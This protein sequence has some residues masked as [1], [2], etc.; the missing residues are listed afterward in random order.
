MAEDSFGLNHRIFLLKLSTEMDALRK[1]K[2]H[3]RQQPES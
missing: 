2:S 1:G 3:R